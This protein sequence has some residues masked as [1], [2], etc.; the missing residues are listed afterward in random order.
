LHVQADV[1]GVFVEVDGV[2]RGRSPLTVADLTPGDHQVV[3]RGE[4]RGEQRVVR[5]TVTIKAGE[6]LTFV[7]SPPASSAAAPGW[8]SVTAPI[9]MQLRQDGKVI[10]TTESDRVMLPSGDHEIG[11]VN[12]TIGFHEERT[13]SVAPGKTAEI[14]VTLPPA[15]LSINAQPW[16]EVWVDGT[17]IGETPIANLTVTPGSHEVLFRHPDLGERRETVVVTL[18]QTARLGVDLRRP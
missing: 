9:V 15:A 10:G 11:I 7:L 3:V 4:V 12:D 8:L 14:A 16:A 13:I 5:R 18:R 2:N 1:P 17:R 6:T